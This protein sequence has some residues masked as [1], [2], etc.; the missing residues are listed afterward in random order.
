M[1]LISFTI[2]YGQ[3]VTLDEVEDGT[4]VTFTGGND[5]NYCGK[6]R[7]CTA[8][9]KNRVAKFNDLRLVGRSGRGE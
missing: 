2:Q 3:I 8:V 9:M 6:L 1:Q 5:E 7:N 4:L